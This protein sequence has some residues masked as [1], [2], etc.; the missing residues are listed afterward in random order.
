MSRPLVLRM[1]RGDSMSDMG[2]ALRS[3]EGVSSTPLRSSGWDADG[4]IGGIGRY[5]EKMRLAI[6]SAMVASGGEVHET[7]DMFGLPVGFRSRSCMPTQLS[8][9]STDGW[10]LSVWSGAGRRV[11]CSPARY[12]WN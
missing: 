11:S 2:A 8:V 6:R 5:S 1:G 9:E 12:A 7:A 4:C 10:R 3:L